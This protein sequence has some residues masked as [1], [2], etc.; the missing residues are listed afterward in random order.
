MTANATD[1]LSLRI[2][3]PAFQ[4]MLD[5]AE[6]E[7]PREA[8]GM[9]AGRPAGAVS[10]ALP[11]ANL[12]GPAAFLADPYS[13][14]L[15]EKHI[16]T[17]ALSLLAIYHSHPGGGACLSALDC[18]FARLHDTCHVVLA[19]AHGTCPLTVRAYRVS[20]TG[21]IPVTIHVTP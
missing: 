2:D 17:Q 12:A 10:L 16:R 7:Q 18:A 9:L 11:L 14:Y 3:R 4:T 15:A 13:Q 8:V 19:L 6:R 21:I 1:T 5:H 20:G